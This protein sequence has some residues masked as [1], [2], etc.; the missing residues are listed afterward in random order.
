[1]DSVAEQQQPQ[2]LDATR[3]P[4]RRTRVHQRSTHAA[5][6]VRPRHRPAQRLQRGHEDVLQPAF[7]GA[8]TS[9]GTPA[10]LP[11]LRLVLPSARPYPTRRS[12]TLALAPPSHSWPSCP[13]PAR[14]APTSTGHLAPANPALTAAEVSHLLALDPG[15]CCTRRAPPGVRMQQGGRVHPPQPHALHCHVGAGAVDRSTRRARR[16]KQTES[17]K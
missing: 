2:R 9:A 4:C 6:S 1:M 15:R 5:V 8:A 16:V 12:S 14:S 13:G 7:S 10:L 3:Q 11:V 17:N